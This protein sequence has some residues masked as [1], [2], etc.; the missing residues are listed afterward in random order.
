MKIKTL[1]L[2]QKSNHSNDSQQNFR[3]HSMTNFNH[4]TVQLAV[5]NQQNNGKDYS[6]NGSLRSN[7]SISS[8]AMPSLPASGHSFQSNP[9]VK[10]DSRSAKKKRFCGF[11]KRNGES[12][13][14][15]MS[16]W[17][18]DESTGKVICPMLRRY[19]CKL[20]DATGDE[21][22]TKSHCPMARIIRTD[23]FL[24]S[25][26]DK[27]HTLHNMVSLKRTRLNSA[28]KLRKF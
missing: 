6:N 24:N 27:P 20:C 4:N 8:A 11:C 13:A 12:F 10:F 17:T 14:V 18:R 23:S 22:H 15:F 26:Y 19:T 3:Q 28:G 16:H 2:E 7:G 5:I 25:L 1:G 9:S 21:A